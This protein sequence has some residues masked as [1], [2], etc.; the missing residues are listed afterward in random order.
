MIKLN[1]LPD[2]KIEYLKTKRTQAQVI[3]IATIV[4]IAM[5]ALVVVLAL[6]VY[7]GQTLQK[8][9]LTGQ[10]QKNAAELKSVPDVDKYLTIQNQLAHITALH[11]NKS[12]FSRLMTYLPSLNPVQPN[13]V[14]ITTV[15]L[16]STEDGVRILSLQGEGKDYTALSTFRD[17]LVN[18]VLKYSDEEDKVV[19]ERLFEA[20]TVVSSGLEKSSKGGSVVVFKIDTTYNPNAFLSSVKDPS[21]SVPTKTTTQSAQASPNVFGKS[22]TEEEE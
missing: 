2:V 13:N 21:V 1:L 10:I 19:E 18:A 20:V 7:G 17:T 14:T 9:Y 5:I 12:D 4:S 3:S 16:S 22:S 8:D 11:D 6:W 15:E